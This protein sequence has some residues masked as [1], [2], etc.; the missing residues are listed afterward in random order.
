MCRWIKD[1][2][3]G[4]V[5]EQVWLFRPAYLPACL[6]CRPGLGV[7]SVRSCHGHLQ[8]KVA[9]Q[10]LIVPAQALPPLCRNTQPPPHPGRAWPPPSEEFTSSHSLY[11]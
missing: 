9:A 8:L 7:L 10:V 1:A 2:L 3:K 5:P 4:D 11:S 6:L